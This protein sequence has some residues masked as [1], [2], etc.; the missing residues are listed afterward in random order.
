MKG[1]G[2]LPGPCNTRPYED[3]LMH[4]EHLH[5]SRMSEAAANGLQG[6]FLPWV[7]AA[8]TMRHSD[9]T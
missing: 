6:L 5:C 3:V 1:A 2:I 4:K 8:G 7:A 9:F